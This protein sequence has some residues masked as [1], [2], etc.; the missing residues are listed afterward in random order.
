MGNIEPVWPGVGLGGDGLGV[1]Y[2]KCDCLLTLRI[3]LLLSLQLCNGKIFQRVTRNKSVSLCSLQCIILSVVWS[4]VWYG[5]GLGSDQGPQETT[6]L[7]IFS[8]KEEL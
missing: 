7:N 6:T 1:V 2:K 8:N 3:R 5:N 4:M